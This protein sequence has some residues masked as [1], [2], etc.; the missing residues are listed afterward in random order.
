MTKINCKIYDIMYNKSIKRTYVNYSQFNIHQR[1]I[2]RTLTHSAGNV[3]LR[4]SS[5]PISHEFEIRP[6]TSNF[7]SFC[8]VNSCSCFAMYDLIAITFNGNCNS[9]SEYST[10]VQM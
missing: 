2:F 4:P 8:N 7:A 10:E 1:M 9:V 3:P 6:I 5:T